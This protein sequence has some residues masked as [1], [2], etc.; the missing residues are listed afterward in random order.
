[1]NSTIPRSFWIGT[2]RYDI[3]SIVPA[4][5]YTTIFVETGV[6]TLIEYG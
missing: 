5:R 6:A 4:A 3:R 2:R 1:M